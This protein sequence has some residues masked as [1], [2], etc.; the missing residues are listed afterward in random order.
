[1]LFE[2]NNELRATGGFIGT[3]G[4][5]KILNGKI[6]NIRVSSIYDLDGQLTENIKPPNPLLNVNSKW[7]MRDSNWFADF[8]QTAK[9]VSGF[10]EKKVGNT[11]S[12]CGYD[13]KLN[14]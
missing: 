13:P 6:Q 8:P 5:L 7:Y 10:Y 4:N 14:Y 3:Y 9:T 12:G 1:M 2:N 11:G